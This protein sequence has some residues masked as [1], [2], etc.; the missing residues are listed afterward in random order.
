MSMTT[1]RRARRKIQWITWRAADGWTPE[2]V[3]KATGLGNSRAVRRYLERHGHGPLWD[4]LVENL[5]SQ[6]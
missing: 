4:A 3:A 2:Q 5:R 1:E 6:S